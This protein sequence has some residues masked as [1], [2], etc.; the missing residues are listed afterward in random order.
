M[1]MLAIRWYMRSATRRHGPASTPL[2][3]PGDADVAPT[4][5]DGII[6]TPVA[7]PTFAIA[8][9][10]TND[11]P[12]ISGTPA[13]SVAEDSLYTFT[14]TGEDVDTADMLRYAITN[15][16]SWATFDETSGVLT[17]TPANADVGTTTDIVITVRDRD[18]GGL[19]A[20]L[21]AFSIEVTNVNDAPTITGTPDPSV[22]QGA[23]YSFTPG[24]GDVDV[25]DT[26][27]YA[28]SNPPS[29]ASFDTATGAL[30]GTP[31]NAD[32]GNYENIVISVT[33]G[34]IATPVALP[35]FAIA[36]TNTNDAPTISGTP[37]TA[38]PKTASIPSRQPARMWILLI[39]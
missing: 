14:P 23:A 10:N 2:A 9:T 33:D 34:I 17:G 36:V 6:A 37:A 35:T 39:C 19:S 30:T 26:L 31:A 5:T 20:S 13:T 22:T 25:G 38:W 1:W 7:L 16:P 24:G 32:V 12:T 3:P 27:V 8:V 29:W 28:I 21:P 15:P 4:V 18:T 11:A